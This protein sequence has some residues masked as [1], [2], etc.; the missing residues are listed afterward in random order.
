MTDGGPDSTPV[1]INATPQLFVS[2]IAASCDF[3]IRML[4]FAV[5]FTYGQ[6]PFYAHVVRDGASLA[7]RHVDRPV[8]EKLGE[9]MT[10]DVDMLSASIAV[11]DV[12]ALHREFEA[13]GATFHQAL[14][15]EPWGAQTFIV[16]DPDGNLVLFAGNAGG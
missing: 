11:H 2:D 15:T 12:A 3:F 1:L 13:A 14:R 8:L 6:P 7:L 10:A 9:A 5:E 16:A 4:G